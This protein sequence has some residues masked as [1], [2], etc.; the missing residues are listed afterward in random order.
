VFGTEFV[1]PT[2]PEGWCRN[3]ALI[4]PT[5]CHVL[6]VPAFEGE[7]LAF[8]TSIN[9]SSQQALCVE[10]MPGLLEAV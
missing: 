1:V 10:I 9:I 6:A 4:R 2:L 8:P 7:I 5:F 3:S